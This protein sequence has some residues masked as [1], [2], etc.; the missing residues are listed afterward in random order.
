VISSTLL[1][2]QEALNYFLSLIRR[3]FGSR[4]FV[5]S[6]VLLALVMQSYAWAAQP[7][8]VV[9]HAQHSAMDHH[10]HAT[11]GY[12]ADSGSRA[13]AHG[14][15]HDA[16]FVVVPMLAHNCPACSACCLAAAVFGDGA[17]SGLLDLRDPGPP[18]AVVLA[19]PL[20]PRDPPFHP[21]R[22]ISLL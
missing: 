15:S 4:G 14:E 12:T 18:A 16:Q 10:L 6:I 11:E 5:A 19:Q 17:A 21:P 20:P 9:Q 2:M 1:A 3:G 22:L 8:H 13:D 7:C